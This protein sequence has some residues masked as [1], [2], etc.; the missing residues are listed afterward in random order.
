MSEEEVLV[1][2]CED[3]KVLTLSI[4]AGE[5]RTYYSFALPYSYERYLNMVRDLPPSR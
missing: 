3:E 1:S 5:G 2:D 4:K